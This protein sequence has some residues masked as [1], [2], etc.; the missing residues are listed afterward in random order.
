MLSLAILESSF[1]KMKLIFEKICTILTQSY[2]IIGLINIIYDID[3]NFT[4][5]HY[6]RVV[7]LFFS[8]K[9]LKLINVPQKL[10]LISR[11]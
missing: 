8:K 3:T 4:S 10:M 2:P 5:L 11:N 7:Y 6:D 1:R 9:L